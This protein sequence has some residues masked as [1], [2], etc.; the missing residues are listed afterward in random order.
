M[1]K[2]G[3][4]ISLLVMLAVITSGFTYAFWAGTRDN[5]AAAV[6]SISIGSGREYT[7][8]V[9]PVLADKVLVPVNQVENS[10]ESNAVTSFEL[11][12]EVT[13]NDTAHYA[14]SSTIAVTLD[15]YEIIKLS[16]ES[17]GLDESD[18]RYVD[19]EDPLTFDGM[20]TFEV[21]S[22]P[23]ITEGDE[24]IVTVLVT[25]QG[26]PEDLAMYNL[27]KQGVLSFDVTFVVTVPDNPANN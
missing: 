5:D 23:S 17:S 21:T 19:D 4:V 18:I 13:W 24:K 11:Q 22:T 3:L 26:E 20:F 10:N 14:A 12:F 6:G 25:F 16:G 8:E 9:N 7:V 27:V 1:K 15:N 2:R